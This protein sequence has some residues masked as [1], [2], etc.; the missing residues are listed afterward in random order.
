M[1]LR[2]W[3][4]GPMLIYVSNLRYVPRQRTPQ[5]Q[6]KDK[7]WRGHVETSYLV[8]NVFVKDE[9]VICDHF[10]NGQ[11]ESLGDM[12]MTYVDW[13]LLLGTFGREVHTN[14]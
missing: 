1:C 4:L 9:V 7:G 13:G 11:V 8:S 10:N 2:R 3:R 6:N 12:S 5:W 14:L